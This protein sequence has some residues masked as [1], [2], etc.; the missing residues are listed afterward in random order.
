MDYF[1]C[2]NFRLALM[3]L[4]EKQYFIFD[5]DGTLVDSN[6][7]K[8]NA[9]FE[10]LNY[11][12]V[13]IKKLKLILYNYPNL[14]RFEIFEKLNLDFIYL[15]TNK[16]SLEY[17]KICFNSILKAE[18]INGASD[19]L[20]KLSFKNK[21]KIIN[22]ATPIYPLKNIINNINICNFIDDVYGRPMTKEENLSAILN[23]YNAGIDHIIIIG[24]G[25]SDR[26]C[27]EKFN[28]D[29]IAFKNE[30]SYYKSIPK[31]IIY[32]YYDIIDQI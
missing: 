28:C 20:K 7:I 11:D 19:F 24:D 8:Y 2:G 14:D 10:V 12:K 4:T 5:F 27:A 9:Y 29:F 15:D 22:S 17:E 18:E 26:V 6:L 13:V 31:N 30:F 21:I 16:L 3:N 1:F 25:E 23:K 32:D